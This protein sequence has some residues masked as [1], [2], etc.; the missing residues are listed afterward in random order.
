MY[1]LDDLRNDNQSLRRR[2]A[3]LEKERDEI[4]AAAVESINALVSNHK[5]DIDTYKAEQN[6]LGVAISTLT[7]DKK[8]QAAEIATIKAAIEDIKIYCN[9]PSAWDYYDETVSQKIRAILKAAG[10]A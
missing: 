2:V 7:A 6:F 9:N 10:M 3:E 4:S 1:T 5:A 8:Q